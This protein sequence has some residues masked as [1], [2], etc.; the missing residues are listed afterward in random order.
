M[1]Y[2]HALKAW[3]FPS[4]LVND[5]WINHDWLVPAF[6]NGDEEVQ[7]WLTFMF[8]PYLCHCGNIDVY[9]GKPKEEVPDTFVMREFK[10]PP[11]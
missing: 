2:E 7:L 11:L 10:L 5:F 3:S 8:W 9:Y 4:Y 1:V 6:R